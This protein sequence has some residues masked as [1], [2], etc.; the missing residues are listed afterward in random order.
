MREIDTALSELPEVT[1]QGKPNVIICS[2]IKGQG[3]KFMSDRP[4]A[5]HIGG[6]DDEH[7]ELALQQ[8]DEY[9]AQRLAEVQ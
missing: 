8:I 1:L 9:T 2:T 3:I 7:L 4:V 5:W 6:L